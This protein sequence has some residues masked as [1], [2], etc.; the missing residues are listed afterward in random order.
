MRAYSQV[1]VL[2]QH[3][4][5]NRKKNGLLSFISH[6]IGIEEEVSP[7]LYV[8]VPTTVG[9]RTEM[10]CEYFNRK[11]EPPEQIGIQEFI[12][13]LYFNFLDSSI[14]KYDPMKI[15]RT[16]HKSY[17]N[18]EP[19][20]IVNNGKVTHYQPKGYNKTRY[21]IDMD[22]SSIRKG[23]ILLMELDELYGHSLTVE[24]MLAS[25]WIN[26]IEAY[27]RGDDKKFSDSILKLLKT[28]VKHR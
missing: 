24:K 28:H 18:E 15:Y 7:T 16:L 5:R 9:L 26:F 1:N 6:F 13:L 17:L 21:E 22:K 14:E 23:E 12:M 27:K 10:L 3:Y 2:G 4:L 8:Q 20:E 11:Y 19:L 25:I